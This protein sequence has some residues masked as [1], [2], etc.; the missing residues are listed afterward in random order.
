[1][2]EGQMHVA[3]LDASPLPLNASTPHLDTGLTVNRQ[4]PDLR[5]EL[6]NISNTS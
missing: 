6:L 1:M 4:W 2:Q 3:R 5:D